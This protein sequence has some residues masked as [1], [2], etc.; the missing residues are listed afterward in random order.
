MSKSKQETIADIVAEMRKDIAEGT[1]GIWSDFG[2]EIARSYA[3][4]IE[5]AEKR[6][7]E[8]MHRA[9]VII[10]GIEMENSDYPHRLW[11]ALEDAY[12]ALSD[13]LGTDGE[14]TAD[15]EEAKA[16]GRHFVVKSYDNAAKKSEALSMIVD[17]CDSF[18][19]FVENG[20]DGHYEA[21]PNYDGGVDDF[22]KCVDDAK[23]A[24]STPPRN[25]DVGTAE[26][27]SARFDSHCRKH[28]GCFTCPL[29]EKDGGVPK[30]CEF[31]W[32]QMPYEEG[33][34]E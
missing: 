20:L 24:L 6:M 12:D 8:S 25:C 23:A 9:M 29:R 14:T 22:L 17:A 32:S 18:H 15:E 31:A 34:A 7:A 19:Q 16:T 4:R 10:A 11:T 33:G 5:A 13:A 3:D 30:H 26:E 27:Q 1:V 21:I 28:M 2:G